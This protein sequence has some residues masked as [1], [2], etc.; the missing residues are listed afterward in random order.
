[1]GY[2]DGETIGI[3]IQL[4][5]EGMDAKKFHDSIQ[6]GRNMFDVYSEAGFD[7]HLHEYKVEVARNGVEP[8]LAFVDSFADYDIVFMTTAYSLSHTNF[9]KM[10]TAGGARIASMPGFPMEFFADNGPM[11]ADYGELTSKTQ[12]AFDNLSNA[13]YVHIIGKGTHMHVKISEIVH[14][15]DGIISGKKD[16]GNLPGAEAY[17]V[18]EHDGDSHGYFTVPAGW[19]GPFA[20]KYA[21]RF[22]VEAGR[23]VDIIGESEEAQAWIDENV[24]PLI[25]GSKDFD[26][27]AELGIGTNPN[28][29]TEF[30]SKIEW[31]TLLAE[32][33]YGSAHFASGNSHGMGGKNNVPTHLDWVVPDVII[34]YE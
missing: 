10:I 29:T 14:A 26:V 31:N 4:A 15:S 34:K 18:P 22:Y 25:F 12:E 6:V 21:V 1:M 2:Q 17:C 8:P 20:M 27:L 19:G 23:F 33:I 3:I 28:V 5:G 30:M 24:K 13:S 16:W 7:V 9:R 11:D 32:K